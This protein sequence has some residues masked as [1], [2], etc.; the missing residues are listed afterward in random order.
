MPI[1]ADMGVK[2]QAEIRGT[3]HVA[4]KAGQKEASKKRIAIY[5]RIS[6]LDGQTDSIVAQREH[7]LHMVRTDPNAELVDVYY[8]EGVSGTEAANRPEL[9]RLLR[10][11]RAGKV[12]EIWC[13]SIS[14][15]A[16]NLEQLLQ[17]ITELRALGVEIFFERES[18]RTLSG[19]GDFMVNLYGSF[20]EY[21]SKSI[22]LNT[23]MGYKS[24][25]MRGEFFYNRPPYGYDSN[26]SGQLVVNEAEAAVVRRI[27]QMCLDGL[28]TYRIANAL[29]AEG[30]PTKRGATWQPGTVKAILVNVTYTGDVLLQK[31]I[32]VGNSPRKKNDGSED[33]YYVSDHHPPIISHEVYEAAQEALKGRALGRKKGDG[34]SGNRYAFS[35]R[36]TCGHCGHHLHR[37][38]SAYEI[39]WICT[40][41][42]SRAC[43][44]T[45]VPDLEV[46]AAFKSIL[47]DIDRLLSLHSNMMAAED[48]PTAKLQANLS[49][50]EA[51]KTLQPVLGAAEFTRRLNTLQQEEETPRQ[52]VNGNAT[53]A[54]KRACKALP[55]RPKWAEVEPIF[56]DHVEDVTI[57]QGGRMEFK[58]K[59]GVR[60]V[61][62]RTY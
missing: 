28:G 52:Q 45:P 18:L 10:D 37:F 23:K 51:V 56:K 38:S 15:W 50:Q 32:R 33:S 25:M 14:R 19:A 16:R 9:Q 53:Q 1:T 13:K 54:L 55:P 35:S 41:H 24:R 11:C 36:L 57:W 60:I 59:C 3:R 17:T 49:Q 12:D 6:S 5:C 4:I 29:A 31:T 22:K 42:N 62:E 46:K 58:F 20:S 34:K 2:T 7:F 26:E 21:E 27:Y 30:I 43:P 44:Q 47:A 39:K 48:D 8:E 40:G 61:S